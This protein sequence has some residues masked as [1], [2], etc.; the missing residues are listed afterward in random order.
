MKAVLLCIGATDE[1]WLT[2]GIALYSRRLQHYIPFEIITKAEDKGWRKLDPT[3][4]KKAEGQVILAALQPGDWAVLLDEKGSSYTSDSFAERLEK[5]MAAGPRRIVWIVGGAYGFSDDVYQAIPDR[6]TLS[7]MTFSHQMV[8][9]FFVEQLY[10][11]CTILRN[12]P[13]HNR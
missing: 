7:N 6:T 12:E 9:L 13:Y 11:A 10:R 1:R 8:R 3:A 4:R 2:D 5:L